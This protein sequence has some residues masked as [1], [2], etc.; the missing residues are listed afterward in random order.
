VKQFGS[1]DVD[2]Y[3]RRIRLLRKLFGENQTEFAARVGIPYKRWHHYERGYPIPRETAF[4]LHDKVPGI[5]TDWI[6]F[7]REGNLDAGLRDRLRK[8]ER[9]EAKDNR[10]L[11]HSIKRIRKANNGR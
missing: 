8:L 7:G 10:A 9:Q 2:D 3:R 5:S 4:I 11:M 6:W 1:F